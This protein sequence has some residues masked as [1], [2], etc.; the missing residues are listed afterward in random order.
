MSARREMALPALA[1]L[2]S[3]L[4]GCASAASRPAG[5]PLSERPG[6]LAFAWRA[7]AEAARVR[8]PAPG[9]L[10][11]LARLDE[12]FGQDDDAARRW[13]D[14]AERAPA[15][16][17]WAMARLLELVDR[18]PITPAHLE[19]A[20]KLPELAEL[21]E[22]LA[23][24]LDDGAA[25]AQARE[26]LGTAFEYQ[27]SRRL[28]RYPGATR[29]PPLGDAGWSDARTS[30]AG[31]LASPEQGPGL[32]AF[33]L[34][35]PPGRHRV[36]I[37]T[38]HA[39]RA[40]VGSTLVYEHDALAALLPER[41]AFEV[42][43]P[44]GGGLELH[45][46]SRT[47]VATARVMVDRAVEGAPPSAAL[48]AALGPLAA[49]AHLELA[50]ADRDVAR[51]SA[52][53]LPDR[54]PLVAL[55]RAR[56]SLADPS[57][58]PE[59]A[60]AQAKRSLSEALT[61][62]LA[63]VEA[64]VLLSRL[65]AEDQE[66]D[67]AARALGAGPLPDL[68]SHV[69]VYTD[70]ELAARHAYAT[71]THLPRSCLARQ[72]LLDSAWDR[73]VLRPEDVAAAFPERLAP[74]PGPCLEAR[75]RAAALLR[76]SSRLD[77]AERL[78]APLV[79]RDAGLDPGPERARALTLA[80]E[81][82]LAR[83]RWSAAAAAAREALDVGGADTFA[84]ELIGRAERL[85]GA[86][87]APRID[88]SADLG[89]PLADT[90]ALIDAHR[91]RARSGDAREIAL[92]D[93]Y[94]RVYAD[95]SQRVRVHRIV[96][97]NDVA[98]VEAVGE[99]PVPDDA[100]IL[101]V[102]TWKVSP[103]G[104]RAL[105]PEDILE[106]STISLPALSPGDYAEWAWFHRVAAEPRVAPGWRAR[107]HAFDSDEGP[108][109]QARLTLSLAP[110]AAWPTFV[111]DPRLAPPTRP[112]DR[113]W[114]FEARDLARVY[115]E[116]LDPRPEVHRMT[117]QASSGAGREQLAEAWASELGLAT[118]AAPALEA[119]YAEA[120]AGLPER[121]SPEAIVEALYDAVRARIDEPDQ[122][123]PLGVP[124]SWIAE[125]RRGS[126][127]LLL[128]ALCRAAGLSCEL[129]L[130]RPLWEGPEPD[131]PDA[132]GLTY[133]LVRHVRPGQPARWLDP[134]SRWMPI[135]LL[136]PALEAVFGISLAAEP[137]RATL[138]ETPG[139]L[140]PG[141]DPTH[142]GARD[143]TLRL[144]VEPGA[145]RAL[146]TGREALDGVFAASW[147]GALVPMSDETRQRILGAIVQQALP[148]ATVEAVALE[149][150]EDDRTPLVWTWRAHLPLSVPGASGAAPGPAERAPRNLQLALFPEA[151]T[152]DTVM[153]PARDSP[154]LV[155]RAARMRLRLEAVAPAGWV[156]VRAPADVDLTYDLG[157]FERVSR[158]EDLG[159]R[160]VVDKRFLLRPGLVEPARYAAWS[161]AAVA[162]DR[163]DVVQFVL[164]PARTT[165]PTPDTDR[166]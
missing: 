50:L 62:E 83:G 29:S 54:S 88:P 48:E 129:V 164:A 81:V 57:R 119:F 72:E 101:V 36:E 160:V 67:D 114:V 42:D 85:L 31:T 153:L 152:N 126:R 76:E 28:L 113:T 142:W 56:L 46:V 148:G 40:W 16:R 75:L 78:L 124:A 44:P 144:E 104:L 52:I 134:A 128:T 116:P 30:R 162:I 139:R 33:R 68:A 127:A 156:F 141:G 165:P 13:L 107:D 5:D 3:L 79:A 11:V 49:L 118:R 166:P 71:L 102:R 23:L 146:A 163:G 61:L 132:S 8:V 58:A 45:L 137:P 55:A 73:L 158:F 15:L 66:L 18:V 86:P 25:L 131:A 121:A 24:R 53:A 10:A 12:A 4:A 47:A 90:R 95:G 103:R 154:L 108:V 14:V 109:A 93:R 91:R 59:L 77:D 138:V 145:T 17:A 39:A 112:D 151:L 89:L 92:D 7:R 64:R 125:R 97:V 110:G 96:R 6:A 94:V 41:F 32:Y 117:L 20:R 123:P 2:L 136:P 100:E 135:G 22:A 19:R 87:A 34:A 143:I 130:A 120:V 133:P 21:A 69:L 35:L 82:A 115:D 26:R 60:R 157:R 147:R 106:K 161:D 9:E 43:L 63:L 27:R 105:E 111:I 37:R 84:R 155:N 149:R 98:A 51:A 159:A 38:E 122:A 65:F 1:A 80:A 70:P 99:L 140:G 150:L 74:T